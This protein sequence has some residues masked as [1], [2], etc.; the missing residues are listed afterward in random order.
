[1]NKNT[2]IIIL[3][4]SC[5][6]LTG[7]SGAQSDWLAIA[8]ASW[9]N[10]NGLATQE[11]DVD[12]GKLGG[13][14]AGQT[15]GIF[16]NSNEANA[17]VAARDVLVDIEQADDYLKSGLRNNNVAE[18]EKAQ[19]LRPEDFTYH[20]AEAAIWAVEGNGAAVQSSFT[21]SDKIAGY[22]I[23]QAGKQN[24]ICRTTRLSQLRTRRDMLVTQ[25][26][27]VDNVRDSPTH[28]E[29][30]NLIDQ[31][32]A[33]INALVAGAPNDFCVSLGEE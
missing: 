28:D 21:E 20:E 24:G 17:L 1:M 12:L 16:T 26:D 33:E 18:I 4:L 9:F 10:T 15:V 19:E 22:S 3:L 25:V 23:K 14:V 11:G 27:D 2:V 6:L 30:I 7:C 8:F 13:Y 5:L 29:M 31:V 32:D